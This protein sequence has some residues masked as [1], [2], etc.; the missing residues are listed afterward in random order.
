[1]LRLSWSNSGN[2]F[3][4][5][6]KNFHYEQNQNFIFITHFIAF[7]I[8]SCQKDHNINTNYRLNLEQRNE[9]NI[10]VQSVL[11]NQMDCEQLSQ[12][13]GN[14]HSEG[15]SYI[16]SRVNSN[17]YFTTLNLND[18]ID[19][20]ILIDSIRVFSFE[21][22]LGKFGTQFGTTYQSII[23][24]QEF[25]SNYFIEG[26]YTVSDFPDEV[27][28]IIASIDDSTSL[29][30]FERKKNQIEYL[31]QSLNK[32]CNNQFYLLVLEDSFN[33]WANQELGRRC[34][35]SA[36]DAIADASGAYDGGVFG[37]A[38]G[39]VVGAAFGAINGAIIGSSV[40][41]LLGCCC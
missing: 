6:L 35:F 20:D 29:A 8:Y 33:F 37:G 4:A 36:G 18:P 39:G 10:E 21:F 25:N 34:K 16:L 9:N 23:N 1:M 22:L 7:I 17:S 40:S 3:T 27:N 11:L 5:K 14:S 28:S 2:C 32:S 24:S 15:L 38:L 41:F 31:L 26:N 13:V 12:I 30:E 19:I